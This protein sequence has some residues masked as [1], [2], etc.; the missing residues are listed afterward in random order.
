MCSWSN[1]VAQ[2]TRAWKVS[3]TLGLKVS[4]WHLRSRG[5]FPGNSLC[6]ECN[7]NPPWQAFETGKSKNEKWFSLGLFSHIYAGSIHEIEKENCWKEV[8]ITPIMSW[9]LV[10]HCL[11]AGTKALLTDEVGQLYHSTWV[12]LHLKVQSRSVLLTGLSP[13]SSLGKDILSPVAHPIMETL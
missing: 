7:Q 13:N 12:R 8:C 4:L 1:S 9:R 2:N 11:S 3:G 10:T 5:N 6:Q